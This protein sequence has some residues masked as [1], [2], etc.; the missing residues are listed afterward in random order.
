MGRY[1]KELGP[2]GE[3]Q[4]TVS[5]ILQLK[6]MGFAASH[7]ATSGGHCDIVI[8][9]FGGFLWLGEAK[10]I[11][12]KQMVKIREGYDQLMDRYSTGLPHQDRGS[13][14]LFCNAPRIDEILT[15]WKSELSGSYKEVSIE[16]YD[17]VGIWFSSSQPHEKTGR[18]YTVR[19]KPISLYFAPLAKT[20]S[21]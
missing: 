10:K 8:T 12:G 7:D 9:E 14:V 11:T 13:L 17:D 16:E 5:L 2:Q 4:L 6:K 21:P 19:H 1:P 15:A 18:K 20:A 3:D